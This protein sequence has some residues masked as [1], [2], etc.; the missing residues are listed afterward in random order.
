MKKAVGRRG[1]RQD[2]V[3][4]PFAKRERLTEIY[5]RRLA[6]VSL[7]EQ[8]PLTAVWADKDVTG[9]HIILFAPPDHRI[10]IRPLPEEG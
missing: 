3:D 5:L 6:W 10:I 1:R 8:L 7:A 2:A 4:D 9:L